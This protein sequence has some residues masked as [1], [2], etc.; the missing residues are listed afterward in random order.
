M[1]TGQLVAVQREG[2][3]GHAPPE[4]RRNVACAARSSFKLLVYS[5][6]IVTKRISSART[7]QLI[8]VEVEVLQLRELPNLGRDGTCQ[9]N[10][11]SQGNSLR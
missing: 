5:Y 7:D 11:Q 3:H 1:L 9:H 4:L 10:F 8:L 2:R 6:S